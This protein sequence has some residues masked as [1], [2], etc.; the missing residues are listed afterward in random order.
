MM[1]YQLASE[2]GSFTAP[3][4]TDLHH[5]PREIA[6]D[7]LADWV[8]AHDLVGSDRFDASLLVWKGYHDDISDLYPDYRVSY[9][10]MGGFIWE[11]L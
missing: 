6:G 5:G 7:L 11:V 2:S 4:S 1:T 9:G 8:R 10:S 3:A